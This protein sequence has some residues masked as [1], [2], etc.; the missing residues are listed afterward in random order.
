RPC[1]LHGVPERQHRRRSRAMTRLLVVLMVAAVASSAR[2]QDST[3]VKLSLGVRITV[4]DALRRDSTEL[5]KLIRM[6]VQADTSFDLSDQ[7]P[8]PGTTVHVRFVLTGSFTEA[9]GRMI[10]S[11]RI[12]D[13]KRQALVAQE[14]A[15][16]ARNDYAKTLTPAIQRAL[17]A[18]RLAAK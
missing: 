13:A 14:N 17:E 9:G 10:A 16:G 18:A 2:A 8:M 12:F 4:D 1:F 3:T 15:S 6:G 7:I 11:I 5:A